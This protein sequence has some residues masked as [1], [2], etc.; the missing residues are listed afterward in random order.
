ML[1]EKVEER[2]REIRALQEEQRRM[3]VDLSHNLQ[4]PLAILKSK[5]DRLRRTMAHDRE[6]VTLEQSVDALS[7]FIYDLM[8]LANLEQALLH[9]ERKTF[10]LSRV[11]EEIVEEVGVIAETRQVSVVSDIASDVCIPGNERRV[12][13]AVMN[14]ASNA[15]KYLG[16]Q[17][18]KR[19]RI[20]LAVRDDEAVVT[21]TDTGIG[22]P[23]AELS[24]VFERFY[25]GSSKVYGSTP[26]TGLGLSIV[27]RIVK[28]HSGTA[29]VESEEGVGTTFTLRFPL[30]ERS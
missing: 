8:A 25:R 14:L 17:G 7:S 15:F 22:I 2:T 3:I 19:V 13:E 29:E 21:V 10:S 5:V 12:R 24:R 23:A 18:Q 11:V 26:G 27:E 16:E 30:R 20:A 28:D 6:L 9:E 1:E 4:T